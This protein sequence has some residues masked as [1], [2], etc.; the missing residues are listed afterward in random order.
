MGKKN[1]SRIH[2]M[3][4][5][6]CAL[7]KRF[8]GGTAFPRLDG[9]PLVQFSPTFREY[10]NFFDLHLCFIQKSAAKTPKVPG[11]SAI[12]ICAREKL[13]GRFIL[14]V[15]CAIYSHNAN[16]CKKQLDK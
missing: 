14:T 11:A 15:N 12:Q 9:R 2:H 16:V 6:H 5:W 1:H 3:A 10:L 8:Y 4:K 13:M 7:G